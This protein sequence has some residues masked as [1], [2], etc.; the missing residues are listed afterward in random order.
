MDTDGNLV[1]TKGS[2][3]D[4]PDLAPLTDTPAPPAGTWI[5]LGAV[6]VYYGQ[7]NTRMTKSNRD[8]MDLRW[9]IPY[10]THPDLVGGAT[11]DDAEGDPVDVDATAASDGTSEYAARRD[12]RHH[13][14]LG[15]DGLPSNAFIGYKIYDNTLGVDGIWDV[16]ESSLASGAGAFADYLWLDVLLFDARSTKAATSE[17]LLLRFGTGGGT[18]DMTNANYSAEQYGG[19]NVTFG[20]ARTDDARIANIAGA[21]SPSNIK[22]NICIRIH[23]PGG[24]SYKTAYCS[25]DYRL[26][27]TNHGVRINGL[28]WRTPELLTAWE[29]R[30]WQTQRIY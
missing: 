23:N 17:V 16:Q 7:V 21:S 25:H 12:H 27:A 3:V 1:Q 4:W 18:L 6:R 2:E 8:I 9:I 5:D 10:H 30:W 28:S 15:I 19:V 26:D 29:L 24:S 11:F 20:G 13:L 14:G 22:T